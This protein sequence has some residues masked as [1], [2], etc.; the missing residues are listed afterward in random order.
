MIVAV[1]ESYHFHDVHPD[2]TRELMEHCERGRVEVLR[3]KFKLTYFEKCP[4]CG[5]LL[6]S[7]KPLS[8]CIVCNKSFY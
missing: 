5:S 7:D 6:W 3:K 1:R 4:E 2:L 8:G